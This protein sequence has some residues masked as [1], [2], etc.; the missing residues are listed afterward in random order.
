MPRCA[1]SV[2]QVRGIAC[3]LRAC[4]RVC[5][6]A[7][8]R[9]CV[10]AAVIDKRTNAGEYTSS[11]DCVACPPGAYCPE[12]AENP[13]PM[14]EGS[15]T[16]ERA[17]TGL[18]SFSCRKRRYRHQNALCCPYN[19]ESKT[20]EQQQRIQVVPGNKDVGD[21][22]VCTAGFAEMPDGSMLQES[23]CSP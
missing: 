5:V 17:R 22:G 8:V 21:C 4:V 6:C 2:R 18:A 9:V 7:C 15:L 19:S 11:T 3:L 10:C 23:T 12:G 20:P 16:S 13:L 14:P 1:G